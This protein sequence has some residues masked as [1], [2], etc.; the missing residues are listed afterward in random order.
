MGDMDLG[1]IRYHALAKEGA[2]V[3]SPWEGQEVAKVVDKIFCFLGDTWIGVKCAPSREEAD[4]WLHRYPDDATPMPYLRQHGWNSLLL[5]GG[6]PGDELEEAVDESYRLV[7]EG[8]PAARRPHGW[9][10][11]TGKGTQRETQ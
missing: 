7:V 2:W 9:S 1:T 11:V 4:E 3:D 6:I 8:L 10:A 5:H